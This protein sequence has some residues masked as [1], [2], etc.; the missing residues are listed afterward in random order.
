M[1]STQGKA[2]GFTPGPWSVRDGD[3]VV[4]PLGNVVAECCGYSVLATD[5]AQRKQGGREANAALLAAAPDLYAALREAYEA[6]HDIINAAGGDEPY[7]REELEGE[8][9]NIAG[10]A[11]AALAK[12]EGRQA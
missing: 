1:K 5:A 2:P 7:T 10:N 9:S 12:A 4:G 8:F 6:L 11:W 3:T